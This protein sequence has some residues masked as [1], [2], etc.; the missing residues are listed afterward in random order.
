MRI[1]ISHFHLQTGGVT[2]VIQHACEALTAAGHRVL[3]AAGEPPQQALPD[4]VAFAHLPALAYEERRPLAGPGE[5]AADL[6]R[7]AREHL[8]D[9]PDLWHIHNHSLGKNL[10]VP[11][12]LIAL[13][14]RGQR[15][16][17]QPHDFAED[18]RPALYARLLAEVGAGDAARLSSLL[19]PLAEHVHYA[20]LNDRD[21]SFLAA[22]DVPGERLH[23]L[24]NA[25][26]IPPPL[27]HA[28][29]PFGERR[30]WLYPTRAI[31]RKNLAELLLWS[32]LA[33]EPDLFAATQ[34]PQNPAEQPRYRRWV[35]LARELDLP[36]KFELGD[37]IKD[38]AGLLA[39]AHA[40]VTTSVAEGFGLAFLEPWL[41]GRPLAGRDLPEI[42]RDFTAAGVDLGGLYER[43]EIPLEWLDAARLRRTMEQ[44]LRGVM[45]AYGREESPAD[46]ERLWTNVVREGRIDFGRLDET[47]Q[48]QVIRHLVTHPRD[49]AALQPSRLFT[50]GDRE[51][52]GR[53]RAVTEQDYA[54]EGY[55][56]RLEQIYRALT[57]ESVTKELGAADATALLDRFLAPERLCLLR[58]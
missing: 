26:A 43:L 10:A 15:L 23:L 19:Y 28:A 54:I 21:R 12:A 42:T 5:L 53:N 52:V 13:A 35:A 25:V 45:A 27:A 20:V 49:R 36:V 46:L 34:A 1:V 33:E 39:S 30:L 22:A 3:V 58:T 37:R 56:R 7:A 50:E 8:G 47:A 38:F 51:R 40:L 6:E 24:P 55:G 9:L 44:A 57:E 32:A 48:E 31:R 18:G 29:H 4:G 2:R 11:G 16:L 14:K 17:L 41:V